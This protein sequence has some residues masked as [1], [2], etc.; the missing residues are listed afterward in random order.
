MQKRYGK[1]SEKEID[2]QINLS[3]L[4]L[5]NEAETFREPFNAEND[6]S[7]YSEAEKNVDISISNK[8]KKSRKKSID[9]LPVVTDV[10]EL[11]KEEQ[12]CPNCKSVLHEMKEKVRVTIEIIPAKVQVHKYISKIYACRN[13][14]KNNSVTLITA[15]GFP[16]PVIPG[17]IASSSAIASIISAKYVDATPFYRQEQNFKRRLVPITRNNMC[18]WS[19]KVANDYFKLLEKKMRSILYKEGA[20]HCD[21]T[22]V[23]VLLEPD[24]PA[25]RKSYI[26][27]T[28]TAE[29]QKKHP[30]ALYRYTMS[31]SAT[32]ARNV[33]NGYEGYLMVDG[34]AGYD[35]L[36]KTGKNGECAMNVRPVS[37][38]VHVR[39]KFVD[40]LKL[41]PA[42]DRDNTSANLAITKIK[43]IFHIDN[44]FKNLSIENRKEKRLELLKPAFDDFFAWA[45]EESELTLP[46]SHYGQAIEYALNQKDKVMRV[47][48]DGRLEL[49]NSM[50]ERT[51]K[52]FVIGRKNWLF[53]NTP[54]GADASCILY[55]IVETSKLNNLIPYEYLKYVMDQMSGA[56][57]I[58]D[59]IIE[60]LLPWSKSI[61]EYVKNPSE[62]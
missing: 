47:L 32:D 5:F 35:S 15:P 30:I 24:K 61:P 38:M 3:D 7:K 2:G 26:W 11:T 12:I 56:E 41:L 49:D 33:L 13:C 17:S 62:V 9:N 25:A 60:S 46:K 52:P 20:I 36:T 54:S 43:K 6:L 45:K 28:T 19:I 59:D 57:L 44:T 39:R 4:P 58:T 27:V 31:R 16:A 42:K 48:E 8:K 40:A 22:Y 29:F 34:Y 23:E 37:C 51:V 18:N 53:S 14:E 10:Y 1:S 55:R 21:E 50:A